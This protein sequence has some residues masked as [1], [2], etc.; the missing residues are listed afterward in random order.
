MGK[1]LQDYKSVDSY[2][3]VYQNPYNE[4]VS[5]LTNNNSNYRQDKH[6]EILLQGAMLERLPEVYTSLVAII[7]TEW[8]SYTHADL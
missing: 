4:I 1:L 6:Y 3:Q 8:A 7:D 5:R 2:C